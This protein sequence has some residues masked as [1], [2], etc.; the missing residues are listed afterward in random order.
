A[1]LRYAR[2]F[3]GREEAT[4][5]RLVGLDEIA[6]TIEV[7]E[8]EGTTEIAV[9]YAEPLKAP[10]QA[11]PVLVAMAKDAR[12][13]EA[14]RRAVASAAEFRDSFQTVLLGTA[15]PDGT[16]DVSVSPAVWEAEEGAFY[17]FISELSS[18][19]GN[20]QHHPQA[21]L[22]MIEDESA[23]AQLLAR[24]RLTFPCSA[25]FIA[26]DA[27]E[28]AGPMEALKAKFGAVMKH[29]ETMTDFHLVRLEPGLGRLVNGFGQAYEVDGRDWTE[30]DHVGGGG[31]RHRTKKQATAKAGEGAAS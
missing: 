28:F 15:M 5:A 16:P 23:A 18:H 11:H 31:H 26:R 29:L 30:L 1:V 10:E 4:A 22:M 17:V 14:R 20:L 19:T 27:P 21:S 8:A 13:E 12:R 6:M 3:G 25:R 24:R 2:I 7:T 9:A